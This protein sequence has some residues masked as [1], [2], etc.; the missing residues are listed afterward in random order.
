MPNNNLVGQ[1]LRIIMES[2]GLSYKKLEKITGIDH[3]SIGNIMRGEL[4]KM[5]HLSSIAMSMGTDL[6]TVLLVSDWAATDPELI[7]D[8]EK[9]AAI[10]YRL[11]KAQREY[12]LASEKSREKVDELLSKDK[13]KQPK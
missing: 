3:G 8:H 11:G 6:S 10:I 12:L 13:D 5:E 9:I 2:N 4:H 7:K 1:I